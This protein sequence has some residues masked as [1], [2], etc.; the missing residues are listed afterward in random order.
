MNC[1]ITTKKKKKVGKKT[2][3]RMSTIHNGEESNLNSDDC[4]PE[5]GNSKAVVEIDN[6]FRTSLMNGLLLQCRMSKVYCPFTS[7]LLPLYALRLMVVD[8]VIIGFDCSILI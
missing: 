7:I 8:F 2:E 1:K 3:F 6:S 4:V 5:M